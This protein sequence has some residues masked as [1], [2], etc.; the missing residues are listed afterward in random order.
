MTIFHESTFRYGHGSA[1][2]YGCHKGN[3]SGSGYMADDFYGDG[4]SNGH[5]D[6]NGCGNAFSIGVVSGNGKDIWRGWYMNEDF[7]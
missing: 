5:G 3:G 1:S 4:I 6:R 2:G 7:I